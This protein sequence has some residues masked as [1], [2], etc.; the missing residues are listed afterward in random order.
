MA[1]G[2]GKKAHAAEEPITTDRGTAHMRDPAF[3][4]GVYGYD[5]EKN[6]AAGRKLSRVAAPGVVGDSESE[7]SVGKQ[8][9]LEATNSIKYRTC[10]WQKVRPTFCGSSLNNSIVISRRSRQGYGCSLHHFSKLLS[11]GTFSDH[12]GPT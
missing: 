7:M 4:T 5:T 8:M 3:E 12:N 11:I 6:T 10:S 9:E 2:F 1:L